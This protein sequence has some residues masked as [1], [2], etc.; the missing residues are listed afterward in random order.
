MIEEAKEL[1]HNA[2]MTTRFAISMVINAGTELL[3]FGIAVTVEPV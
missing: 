3:A 1:G 2:I